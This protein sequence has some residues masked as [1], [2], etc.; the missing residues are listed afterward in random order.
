MKRTLIIPAL[1]IASSCMLWGCKSKNKVDISSEHTTAAETMAPSTTAATEAPT[2]EEASQ[3]ADK[4][5]DS[6]Q[7]GIASSLATYKENNVSIE[8]PVLSGSGDMTAVNDLLK[9]NALSVIKAYGADEAKDT[10]NIKC[11]VMSISNRRLTAVYTGDLSSSGAA[12]PVS[13]YYTNTVDLDKAE[14]VGL[15][16]YADPYTMAGYV[17]SEDC[18]F[19][20]VDSELEAALKEYKNSQSIDY[21]HT[22][23]KEADFPLKGDTFPEAF[24]YEKQGE[25]YIS[26]S[27]PH[28]LGDYAVVVFSPDTK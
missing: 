7:S 21:F 24:S 27:V 15:S 22:L 14:D 16:T 11:K 25:I 3:E 13:I 1:V 19:A 6:S 18:K 9:N 10:L 23:F 8:Y 12:H 20:G 26:F 4:G 28:A 2:E 17:M 5:S